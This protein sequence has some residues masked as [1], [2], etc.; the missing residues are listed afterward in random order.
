MQ[1]P[2]QK[3]KTWI[4]IVVALVLIGLAVLAYYLFFNKSTEACYVQTV[5]AITG[6]DGGLL[7]NDRYSGTVEAKNTVKIKLAEDRT[8]DECFVE[9]GDA[10]T[11][12]T[13][14]FSYDVDKLSL[15]YAQQKIDYETKLNSIQT[16]QNDVNTL[17]KQ[18]SR[19]RAKVKA[20]LQVQLSTAELNLKKETYE[21][22]KKKKE[23]DETEAIMND[24][25]VRATSVG[26]VRSINPPTENSTNN[27]SSND[28]AYM[29]IVADKDYWIKGTV[30]EQT[31]YQL[32]TGSSV[33][34][35]S[36]V[37][38]NQIWYGTITK[39]NTDEPVTNQNMYYYS[40]SSESSS[41]YAFYVELDNTE[42][43]M[44]GQHVY[45]ELG[46]EMTEQYSLIRLPSYYLIQDG[47]STYVYAKD[48]KGR[49]EKREVTIGDYDEDTDTYEI[50]AG[51]TLM[52]SIAFPDET[53]GVGMIANDAGYATED[54]GEEY[55]EEDTGYA[56]S[57][58]M[59]QSY[60]AALEAMG[61]EIPG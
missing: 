47:G 44:M 11:P 25:I 9:V 56:V 33:I 51:L 49:I 50:V 3:K 45:I 13:A 37:D 20:E 32:I 46:E 22:E 15:V 18:I 26:T 57:P 21:A 38:K 48:S 52:D 58:G 2:K 30:S 59:G 28:D 10:V 39:V 14:L 40:D 17:E 19:A 60:G 55:G 24:N 43:L 53:V 54:S 5:A 1:Q 41:K 36:R 34:V 35:R 16:Y 29:T 8:V 23:L 7:M 31:A 4:I 27:S 42:G 12:G 61:E 6:Q